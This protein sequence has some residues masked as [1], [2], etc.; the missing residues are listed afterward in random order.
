[1]LQYLIHPAL[2]SAGN[3][4]RM[5]RT[6]E[7]LAILTIFPYLPEREKS[8]LIGMDVP[9]LFL[10]FPPW[11]AIWRRGAE[12]S[13]PGRYSSSRSG[14]NQAKPR[15]HP[16]SQ[17]LSSPHDHDLMTR[18]MSTLPGRYSPSRSWQKPIKTG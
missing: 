3:M 9:I 16:V 10:S 5:S 1:M 15:H 4:M 7:L 17:H 11:S 12:S 13:L 18:D 2:S 6:A 14:K 8:Q